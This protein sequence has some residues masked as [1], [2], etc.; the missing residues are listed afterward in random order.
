MDTR[1]EE[2]LVQVS[3]A[4]RAL[5]RTWRIS[6]AYSGGPDSSVL[7]EAL[8]RLRNGPGSALPMLRALHVDHGLQAQSQSWARHC[9][10]CCRS[11][12]VE[13][14]VLKVLL[15][16]QASQSLEDAARKARYEALGGCLE[17]GEILCT[18]QHA[19]DQAETLLLQLLRGAGP[20]GLA[21]MPAIREFHAGYLARPMLL[22]DQDLIL[23]CARNWKLSVIEDPAN[24][25]PRFARTRARALLLNQILEQF[26]GA[27]KTLNRSARLQAAASDAIDTLATLDTDQCRG[28]MPGTLAA[29]A[30]AG[31]P[32]TRRLEVLRCW[33]RERQQPIPNEARLREVSRQ[34]TT[35]GPDRQ[36]AIR[37]AGGEVRRYRDLIHA[38]KPVAAPESGYQRHWHLEEE[39]QLPWGRLWSE[40][41]TGRG[42]S[43]ELS[44]VDV[45]LRQGGEHCQPAGCSHRRSLK[46]LFQERGVAPWQRA[47]TPLIHVAGRLVAVAGLCICEGCQARPGEPG[48]L[49]HWRA[50]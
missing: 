50:C 2:L 38:L 37:W 34:M 49:I 6:V 32:Q 41:A 33:L 36:P 23:D 10:S 35:A 47:R 20:R 5:P 26:P 19:N 16:A 22:L 11:R 25:D 8:A 45:S 29:S 42:L 12:G 39:L 48:R 4:L 1:G 9:A 15:P 7:L 40:P 28:P 27:L 13:F 14:K 30:L 46:Q 43:L 31:L 3:R 24:Q 21:A 18:A 17:E 44:E